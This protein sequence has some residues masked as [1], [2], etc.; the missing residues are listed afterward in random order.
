MPTR[1]AREAQRRRRRGGGGGVARAAAA[2][3]AAL[4][5]LLPGV[6]SAAAATQRPPPPP[7]DPLTPSALLGRT[8]DPAEARRRARPAFPAL[9][10]GGGGGAGANS[11]ISSRNNNNAGNTSPVSAA[12]GSSFVAP[13]SICGDNSFMPADDPSFCQI[14]G[15]WEKAD[16][17]ADRDSFLCSAF[18]I[19]RRTLATAGHCVYQT[20]PLY[21]TKYPVSV[22]VWC[23]G[24]DG[25]C[26]AGESTTY[27]TRVLTTRR[28]TRLAATQP[29]NPWDVAVI[30]VADDLFS[31]TGKT[32]VPT[33]Q[34]TRTRP[35]A[36]RLVGYPNQNEESEACNSEEYADACTQYEAT[37]T[38]DPSLTK[39]GYR[40]FYTSTSLD[41]CRGHS[42]SAVLDAASGR[43]VAVVS[44]YDRSGCIN[45]F[46]PLVSAGNADRATCERARGGASVECLR[47]ALERRGVEP[48]GGSS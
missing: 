11:G 31:A 8:R 21:S 43:A 1:L 10:G 15:N 27:G 41:L 35:F 42:G 7:P 38:L 34:A 17:P 36:A 44:G 29:T 16:N 48:G 18:V 13:A 45:L 12:A 19:G 40:G 3:W 20:D 26:A 2:V 30:A 46:A 6:A 22:D 5:V 47:R 33:A 24:A 25:Q 32:A 14:V 23:Y 39:R 9:G 4:A 37:G 28:Y